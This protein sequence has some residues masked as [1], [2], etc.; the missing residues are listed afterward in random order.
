MKKILIVV[1]CVVLIVTLVGCG[2]TD[3][4][5]Q[6]LYEFQM[7]AFV[8]G[9]IAETT[10]NMIVNIWH[11]AIFEEYDDDT[12]A[13][14]VKEGG[15]GYNDFNT[16]LALYMATDSYIDNVAAMEE[17]QT[18]VDAMFRDLKEPPKGCEDG[19]EIA[20]DIYDAYEDMVNLAKNPTGS[21]QT[22]SPELSDADSAFMNA[23]DKLNR[24]FDSVE[25]TPKSVESNSTSEATE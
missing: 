24:Y 5:N 15:Y 6:K 9:L 1:L 22:Y 4:Y 13:Y 19:Y 3:S 7:N 25:F 21:L 12:K 23:Y 20:K 10:G 8:G 11:D 17:N 2:G 16:A 18:K 14:A